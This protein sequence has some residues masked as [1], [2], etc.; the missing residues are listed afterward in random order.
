MGVNKNIYAVIMAGGIGS[1]FWPASREATPKQFLDILGTGE[2]LLQTTFKRFES[3]CPSENIF[4]VTN[5]RY[6]GLVQEQVKGINEDQILL[7]P[8]G[9]NT[10]PCIA[11]AAYKI[12]AKDDQAIMIVA[13]SDHAIFDKQR[14]TEVI[15]TAVE[16][17]ASGD[18]LITLGIK[19]HRPETGYGYIQYIESEDTI[20]KVK[21]FTEKPG[22]QLA[23][24]FVESGDFVWN[25]GIFIW[26]V[27][28]ILEAFEKYLPDLTEIF[29]EA[30]GTFYLP[31][32]EEAI[33]FV[34]SQ[35]KSMSIDYGVME[36]ADNVYVIPSDFGWSDIGSWNALH[37]I[38]DRDANNNRLEGNVLVFDVKDSFIS[39]SSDKLIVASDL[40]GYLIA[41]YGNAI[42]ICKKD[43]EE[44]FR[45]IFADVKKEKGDKYL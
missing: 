23:T 26:H 37:E 17:A 31:E 28:A 7:E 18:R 9:R 27:Q 30:L 2:S 14:F 15:N 1:R 38:S 4:I 22:I 21:T 41:E 11:Y 24:T 19:P 39:T 3:V 29:H 10:A 16:A 33:K 12:S 32:E 6:K 13:P 42:L 25:S 35:C 44:R 43:N 20:K 45:K 8:I 5:Q 34:Y 36:K 40:D